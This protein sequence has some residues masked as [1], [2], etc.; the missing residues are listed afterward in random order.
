MSLPRT[1]TTPAEGSSS[2]DNMCSKVDLPDPLGPMMHTNS[3][4]P[5]SNETSRK[6]ASF[7]PSRAW[8][9]YRPSAVTIGSMNRM[10]AIDF[11]L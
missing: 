1:R 10:L 4:G 7:C 5:T 6:I 2:P 3:D 8:N 11:A 9:L